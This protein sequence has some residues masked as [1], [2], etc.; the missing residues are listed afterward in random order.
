MRKGRH[1]DAFARH[2]HQRPR[3]RILRDRADAAAEL[4][5]LIAKSVSTAKISAATMI[6]MVMLETVAPKTV[7][8][9]WRTRMIGVR[10]AAAISLEQLGRGVTRN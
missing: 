6:T 7:N 5:W 10:V 1:D 3:C 4:V 9:V 8:C 2:T